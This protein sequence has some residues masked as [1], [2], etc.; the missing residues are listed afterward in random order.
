VLQA[1]LVTQPA[2][3]VV[4]VDINAKQDASVVFVADKSSQIVSLHLPAPILSIYHEHVP[5]GFSVL[6]VIVLAE[7]IAAVVA[8]EQEVTAV[9]QV[10]DQ[11]HVL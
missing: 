10:D 3:F 8:L 5:N 2:P 4:Q 9:T 11:E 6:L 1:P 7:Q